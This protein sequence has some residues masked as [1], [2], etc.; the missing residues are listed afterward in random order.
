[1]QLWS[2]VSTNCSSSDTMRPCTLSLWPP[3]LVWTALTILSR[4]CDLAECI[5]ALTVFQY[6]CS[7][8]ALAA[9]TSFG[10]VIEQQ[11][12]LRCKL[13]RLP[14]SCLPCKCEAAH[15]AAAG[16]ADMLD[17]AQCTMHVCRPQSA[18]PGQ[19]RVGVREVVGACLAAAATLAGY[20]GRAM[21]GLPV[22]HPRT[23][24]NDG[25]Q[26]GQLVLHRHLHD[27]A[28]GTTTLRAGRCWL[29]EACI[30]FVNLVRAVR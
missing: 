17:C 8:Q 23:H 7:Q 26:G 13:K 1:M 5:V 20:L 19:P 9:V 11:A 30:G 22:S 29:R 2:Q 21:T 4:Q 6:I 27:P 14:A 10:A 15:A 18:H 28:A 3:I 12:L 24:S 25:R 16:T